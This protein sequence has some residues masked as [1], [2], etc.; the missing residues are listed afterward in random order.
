MN[1]K[2]LVVTLR[3]SP[4]FALVGQHYEF[5]ADSDQLAHTLLIGWKPL[6]YIKISHPVYRIR[7]AGKGRNL[8]NMSVSV[9]VEKR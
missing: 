3:V 2:G 5:L 8:D 4:S 6:P 7:H 9:K 1:E